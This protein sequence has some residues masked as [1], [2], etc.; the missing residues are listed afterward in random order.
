MLWP[1]FLWNCSN[2][3][4]MFALISNI[5]RNTLRD[6]M[7]KCS[8]KFGSKNVEF[9]TSRMFASSMNPCLSKFGALRECSN[10]EETRNPMQTFGWKKYSHF[11]PTNTPSAFPAEIPRCGLLSDNI[12]YQP[13]EFYAYCDN[14][15]KRRFRINGNRPYKT[16]QRR[17]DPCVRRWSDRH[18]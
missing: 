8:R 16:V 10:V 2:K 17:P 9:L 12:T 7:W 18:G 6:F 5:I 14:S 13:K 3:H 11:S 15:T 4:I 1:V